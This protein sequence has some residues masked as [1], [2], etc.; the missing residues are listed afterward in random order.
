MSCER[1]QQGYPA[2]ILGVIV[3]IVIFLLKQ[4]VCDASV[5]SVF[6]QQSLRNFVFDS[7]TRRLYVG[8]VNAV[9]KLSGNLR[10]YASVVLG[11]HEDI[12]NC[13]DTFSLS[14]SCTLANVSSD[15]DSQA[16]V[17]DPDNGVLIACGTLYYGS[18][19]KI[20]MADFSSAEY[21]YRPVVPND[22]SK[23]VTVLVAPGFTG[24]NMLYVGAA[25]ST[26]GDASLRNKVRLFSV[27]DLQT[28]ELA[29][30][31]TSSSSFKE[32]LPAFR[33]SF[34]MQFIRAYHFDGHVYFF[35]RRPVSLES[36]QMTSHM[37]RIC[38]GD[39]RMHS[40]VELQLKCSLNDVVYPYLRD[41]T[42]I[43]VDPPLQMPDDS[44]FAGPTL[45][46]T[47]TSTAD[48]AGN[49]AVCLY[50]VTNV[51][52]SFESVI[53][54]CFSGHGSKGPEYIAAPEM[55]TGTV[56]SINFFIFYL[57]VYDLYICFLSH[58][59]LH[60]NI[61]RFV[62]NNIT[63]TYLFLSKYIQQ[64]CRVLKLPAI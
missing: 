19:A 15:S 25:Y 17:L 13:A 22:G 63:L 45:V 5:V 3:V 11:P 29:S 57:F 18:C 52:N 24:T 53:L 47:F 34:A 61:C 14:L 12:V 40:I 64:I 6:Q 59:E 38:T 55:C 49:S 21:I 30:L 36:D 43:D 51:E 27:R 16:L 60:L 32:L 48:N 1:Y 56:G 28:F 7:N 44:S 33:E 26:R 10:Q 8:G 62:I 35:F 4:E 46:G 54:N 37:L 41:I 2:S 9:Y 39:Q 20:N 42:L 23:S 50:Q 31:E 58:Y